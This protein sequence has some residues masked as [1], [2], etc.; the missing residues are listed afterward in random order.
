MTCRDGHPVP[1]R[2]GENRTNRRNRPHILRFNQEKQEPEKREFFNRNRPGILRLNR[3]QPPGF[4]GPPVPVEP[5][6]R[7][8]IPDDMS[9]LHAGMHTYNLHALTV[10]V[11]HIKML[12]NS[13][14]KRKIATNLLQILKVIKYFEWF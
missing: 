10:G 1:T 7:V 14:G 5:E 3:K 2:T 9:W 6:N 4:S 13:I 11:S 8:P 12:P